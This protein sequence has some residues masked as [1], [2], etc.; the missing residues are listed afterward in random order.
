MRPLLLPLLLFL[1]VRPAWSEQVSLLPVDSAVELRSYGFGLIPFDGKFTRFHGWMRY[2][3]SH[4]GACQV[5]LEIE[6]GS[7]AMSS[8]RYASGLLDPE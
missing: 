5:M 1:L 7:L 3:P 6:A 4:P 8:T 2:D